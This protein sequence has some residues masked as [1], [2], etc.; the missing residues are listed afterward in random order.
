M[1]LGVTNLAK[2]LN[3]NRG[4]IYIYIKRGLPCH[5]ISEKKLVFDIEEVKAWLKTR[6][7]G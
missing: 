1:I 5:R 4:T 6:Y 2:K 3:V 7:E